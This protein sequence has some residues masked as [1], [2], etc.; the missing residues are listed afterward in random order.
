MSVE[1]GCPEL[2]LVSS[3]CGGCHD[4]QSVEELLMLA[5]M[6]AVRWLRRNVMC[7]GVPSL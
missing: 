3:R 2:K 6:V 4:L 5:K 1:K 7:G